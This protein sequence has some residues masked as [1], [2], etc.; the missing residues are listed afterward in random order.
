MG[1]GPLI[2]GKYYPEFGNFYRCS[3]VFDDVIYPSVEH[4]YQYQ[5]AT[6]NPDLQQKIL[7]AETSQLAY[8][9]GQR[10]VLPDDWST[11][12]A[13]WMKI[14]ITCK[15]MQHSKLIKL[16]LETGDDDIVFMENEREQDEWDKINGRIF[17]DLRCH[18]RENI[19][20]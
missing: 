15:I 16:L 6:G 12:K 7:T 14:G 17:S 3:F 18:L 9:F 8:K 4:F 11:Q 19:L 1:K 20:Q 10:C 13:V 5:K 2:D